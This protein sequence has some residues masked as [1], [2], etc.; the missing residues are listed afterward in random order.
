MRTRTRGLEWQISRMLAAGLIALA[1]WTSAWTPAAGASVNVGTISVD[2][3]R[4]HPF[5][6][7]DGA[8]LLAEFSKNAAYANSIV[9]NFPPQWIQLV[10]ISKAAP[11]VTPNP[12]RPFIDPRQGQPLPQ[13]QVGN[14]TPFYDIT[15]N[16]M[17]AVINGS[18]TTWLTNGTG[19]YFGDGARS[20]NTLAPITFT[21]E[22]LLV[23]YVGDNQAGKKVLDILGGF[24]WGYTLNNGQPAVLQNLVALSSNGTIINAFNAA[25]AQDFPAY[26]MGDIS[27]LN[28]SQPTPFMN[29]SF[30]AVPEPGAWLLASEGA[31]LLI[32]A[33]AYRR[34]IATVA[35]AAR[36]CQ[37]G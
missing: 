36:T 33:R 35:A 22:T 21:A 24:Q 3:Y 11:P 17:A 23:S 18:F 26:V 5:A 29:V 31:A 10:S 4:T 16:T 8:D 1:A 6:T 19:K 20:A 37:D 9:A 13:G 30:A 15:G 28:P 12:N 7:G 27:L 2:L 25:L 32:A 14:N 34:R